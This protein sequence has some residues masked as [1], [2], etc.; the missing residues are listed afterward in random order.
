ME[1]REKE[2]GEK[3]YGYVGTVMKC[4]L[5]HPVS[6][7]SSLSLFSRT[8]A[9]PSASRSLWEL[10]YGEKRSGFQRSQLPWLAERSVY[11]LDFTVV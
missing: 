11:F 1:E 7:I 9:W 4:W 5:T 8:I 2:P 3:S 6:P 10:S